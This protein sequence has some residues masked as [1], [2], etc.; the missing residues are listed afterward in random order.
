MLD[1]QQVRDLTINLIMLDMGSISLLYT[2]HVWF[3]PLN[4]K[5]INIL[6]LDLVLSISN[7]VNN[8]IFK[9]FHLNLTIFLNLYLESLNIKIR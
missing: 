5:Q 3:I 7:F 8:N 6:S 9:G 1:L 2:I 4:L